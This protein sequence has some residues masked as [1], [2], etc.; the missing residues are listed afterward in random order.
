[1]FTRSTLFAAVS[2][3][4][5]WASM[6]SEGD[7]SY[8]PLQANGPQNWGSLDIP[9]NECSGSFNSPVAVPAMYSCDL[10]QNYELTVSDRLD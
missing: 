6:A 10:E 5:P 8:D 3:A 2:L 9:N 7:Y 1:M 4:A